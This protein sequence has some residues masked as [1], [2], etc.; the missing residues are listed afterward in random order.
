[1]GGFGV[2]SRG[3]RLHQ[4]RHLIDKAARASGAYA[5]HALLQAAGKIDDLGVL[6]AQLDG[7]VG[8]RGFHPQ[9]RG[10]RRYLLHKGDLQRLA[11]SH[12]AAARDG[13]PQPAGG[14]LLPGFL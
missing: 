5:V 11:Q 10:H 9:G 1:M 8:L 4:G 2:Q 14:Q 7:H 3:V 13:Q 12:A 6:T